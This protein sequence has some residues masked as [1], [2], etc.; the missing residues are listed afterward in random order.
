MRYSVV[1]SMPFTGFHVVLF[2]NGR[3]YPRAKRLWSLIYGGIR[4][5]RFSLMILSLKLQPAV[6]W[7]LVHSSKHGLR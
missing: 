2:F 6:A 7:E 1:C 4:V 5:T 3:D